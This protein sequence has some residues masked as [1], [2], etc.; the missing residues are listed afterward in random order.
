MMKR[1]VV[2]VAGLVLVTG[3][4]LISSEMI[5][6]G[7]PEEIEPPTEDSQLLDRQPGDYPGA[8]KTPHIEEVSRFVGEND[9]AVPGDE[10]IR[11]E[12][13]N[14]FGTAVGPFV[15]VGGKQSSMVLL[16]SPTE[17]LASIPAG[18]SGLVKVSVKNPDG[19]QVDMAVD[20]R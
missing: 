9:L 7:A 5:V 20:L 12:G 6:T 13:T 2:F 15:T 1:P 4:A 11:I 18:I 16:L 10:Y 19:R 14:F 3:L 8:V 17:I